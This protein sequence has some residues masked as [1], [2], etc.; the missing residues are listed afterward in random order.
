[1]QAAHRQLGRRRRVTPSASR[2]SARADCDDCA[3]LPCFGT[4]TPAAATTIAAIVDTLIDRDPSPPVPQ[5]STIASAV[6]A[7]GVIR[8]RIAR[9]APTSSSTV[10]PFMR[11]AASS[12]PICAGVAS[13]SMI[14][15]TTAAISSDVRSRRSITRASASRIATD[16]RAC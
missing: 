7:T 5:V 2:T 15:P 3:R 11:S 14:S 9:A 10:S 16:V 13:P 12:A 4:A 1:M 8:A 6:N